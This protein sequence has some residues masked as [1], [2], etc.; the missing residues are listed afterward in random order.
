MPRAIASAHDTARG[1]VERAEQAAHAI[2]ERAHAQGLEGARAELAARLLELERARSAALDALSE[3]AQRAARLAA[4]HV[5]AAE[6]ALVPERI[7][8]IVEEQLTRVR[9]ARRAVLHVHPDDV[10]AL[11]AWLDARVGAH[12]AVAAIEIVGDAALA[13]G[14]C[15][16]VSDIGTIDARVE[17]RLERLQPELARVLGKA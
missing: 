14:G 4:E 16:V 17:T 5:I 6:L 10:P 12:Q 11:R 15:V 9:R 13:R 3:H 7:A 2:A 8:A 1:I